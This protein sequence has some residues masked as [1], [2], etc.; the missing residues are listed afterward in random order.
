MFT[1]IMPANLAGALLRKF[2]QELSN[3]FPET[4][5]FGLNPMVPPEFPVPFVQIRD[6]YGRILSITPQ[7]V[8]ISFN[9]SSGSSVDVSKSVNFAVERFDAIWDSLTGLGIE[10]NRFATVVNRVTQ[11]AMKPGALVKMFCKAETARHA[12]RGAESF[13]IHAHKTFDAGFGTLNS[14]VRLRTAKQDVSGKERDV[15]LVEQDMNTPPSATPNDLASMKSFFGGIGRALDDCFK[16]Y[17][18]K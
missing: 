14:W 9:R 7:R 18:P 1:N 16:V 2:P 6:G 10:F 12:F 8:E 13:E 15:V 11:E 5:M 4:A 17:F 3:H